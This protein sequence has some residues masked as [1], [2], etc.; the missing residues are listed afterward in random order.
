MKK[1]Y[2]LLL[3]VL[4]LVAL[5]GCEELLTDP[6]FETFVVEVESLSEETLVSVQ[7]PYVQDDERSNLEIIESYV[8]LDY[9]VYDFGVFIKGIDG[10]YPR[11]YNVTY[12]YWFALY[13][14]GT[15]SD[16][17]IADV[18]LEKD[19]VITFKES[20]ALDET[21]LMVDELIVGFIETHL[22][23]Y[24]DA[25]MF[26]H[27]VVAALYQLHQAGH[28][29]L[30]L[31]DQQDNARTYLSN[32]GQASPSNLFKSVIINQAFMLEM[33]FESED[34]TANNHYDALSLLSALD[35]LDSRE[36]D[37]NALVQ[38]LVTGMPEYAD[39]DYAGM[40]LEVL[41]GHEDQ[42]GVNEMI[43]DL[44]DTLL[45]DLTEQ[46]MSSWG[47]ANA[48]STANAII[49]LVAQGIDPRSDAWTAED[50][51]LIEALLTYAKN[52]AFIWKT[53]ETLPDMMF[54][55]PQA[56]AALVV[57]KV[58]RDTWGNPATP[59]FD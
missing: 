45:M 32:L 39:A 10:H 1:V 37:R 55:T 29:V 59:L 52:D 2:G 4:T 27:H 43:L 6:T 41:A 14:N 17:G 49:G 35:V 48:A 47:A 38:M 23:T 40:L 13:V 42:E 53:G 36:E 18:V 25:A 54:S 31:E 51:D 11:E 33:A 5:A 26:N 22:E 56:F 57:Y 15:M 20:T 9:D 30:A 24:L 44:L 16:V 28:E 19:L 12:N 3:V 46:G 58:F 50:T 8:T 34:I 7:I 21:D